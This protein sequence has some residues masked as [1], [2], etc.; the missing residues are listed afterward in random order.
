MRAVTPIIRRTMISRLH[1]NNF[2][3]GVIAK[4][5]MRIAVDQMPDQ[6]VSSPSGVMPNFPAAV[7]YSNQSAG[8]SMNANVTAFRPENPR[9]RSCHG[10][11][12][13]NCRSPA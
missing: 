11:M 4:V 8:P 12:R 2:A 10:Q 9:L 1:R 7:E 3:P 13:R 6:N 5:S